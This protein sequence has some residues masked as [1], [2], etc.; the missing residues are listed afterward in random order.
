[1]NCAA[2]QLFPPSFQS[3]L[4]FGKGQHINQGPLQTKKHP[5]AKQKTPSM[6]AFFPNSRIHFGLAMFRPARINSLHPGPKGLGVIA[7]L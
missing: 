5:G 6:L 1:V 4:Y 2:P 7:R 3:I